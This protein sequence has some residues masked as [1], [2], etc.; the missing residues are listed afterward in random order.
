LAKNILDRLRT[1]V[2]PKRGVNLYSVGYERLTSGIEKYH[3]SEL[4]DRGIIRFVNGRWGAGKTHFF[5]ILTD[6]ANANGCLVASVEFT[7]GKEVTPNK[8]ETVFGAIIRR[9][10][11][12]SAYHADEDAD[13]GRVLIEAYAFLAEG[14]RDHT[15]TVTGEGLQRA[16]RLLTEATVMDVDFKKMVLAYWES[17]QMDESADPDLRRSE[18]IGWFCGDGNVSGARRAFGVNKVVSAANA[19]LMLQSLA[20]LVRLSGYSGL[21]ILLDEMD[22]SYTGLRKNELRIVH[23]L[24]RSLIDTIE[25]LQGLF[26]VF[27]TTPG[28]YNDPERGIVNYGA[29]HGRVGDPT[30]T[31]PRALDRIWDLDALAFTLDQYQ[32]AARKIRDL[33]EV[34]NPGCLPALPSEETLNAF[35]ADAHSDYSELNPVRFWRALV[36]TIAQRMSVILESEGEEGLVPDKKTPSNLVNEAAARARETEQ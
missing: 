13:F 9:I 21:V 23:D 22:I 36:T 35:V 32:E 11:T 1:G 29:L 27:A 2:P 19:R 5:R 8:F 6:V 33:Y 4:P 30:N 12:P 34:A 20:A 15:V 25:N 14:R 7:N 31:P 28:F 10:Q 24:L 16:R 3:L 26:M 18:I 17:Y